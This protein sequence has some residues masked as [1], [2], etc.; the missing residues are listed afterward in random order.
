MNEV[1]NRLITNTKYQDPQQINESECLGVG[2]E[3]LSDVIF[4]LMVIDVY[5]LEELV[6]Y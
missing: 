3:N 2:P 6:C 5:I 1:T 4:L